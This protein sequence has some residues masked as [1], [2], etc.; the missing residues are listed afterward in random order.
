MAKASLFITCLGNLFASDVGV[1]TVELLQKLDVEVDFPPDQTCCGQPHFNNGFW[2]DARALATRMI[3]IFA[4]SEHVVTS[5]GCGACFDA[6]P[7]KID[8]P[9][10]LIKSKE[11]QVDERVTNWHER[12]AFKFWSLG[13]RWIWTY[14]FGSKLVRHA[15]SLFATKGWARR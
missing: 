13:L 10:L 2:D 11:R 14:R 12:A 6:C 4:D 9:G 15:I 7:V 1:A 5:S 8:I 3:D